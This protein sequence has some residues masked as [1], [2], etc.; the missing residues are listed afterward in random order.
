[1]IKNFFKTALRTLLRNKVYSGIN[2][3]GLSL[4]LAAAMLILLYVKDEVSYDRFLQNVGQIYRIGVDRVKKDGSMSRSSGITGL[5]QG[6]RFAAGVPDIGTYVRLD[7]D[8]I[9]LK[10]GADVNAQ[11]VLKVDSNFLSVFSFPLLSGNP[12]TALANPNDVVISEDLAVKQ[13]GTKEA[14]GKS[15]MFRGDSDRF[16]PYVVRGVAKRCP[17]N[18]SIKFDVLMPMV[19]SKSDMADLSN[20]SNFFINT[21]LV[22]RP[23]SDPHAVEKKMNAVYLQEAAAIIKDERE[24]STEYTDSRFVLQ[25]MRDLH[26]STKYS[27]ANGLKDGSDP[28]YSYILSGIAFFIL[29]IACINF[30]NLTVARSVKRAKEIGIRKVVGSSRKQLIFQFM[31]ESMVLCLIAF[32][33]ALLLVE[34]FL[35]LFNELANKSLALAYLADAKLVL[36]YFAIFL[37]TTFLAG[38]YP[39]LVLSGYQPVETLYQRFNLAGKNYLQK[40]LVVLQFTLASVLIIGTIIIYQQFLFL[41][42]TDLG[43]DDSHVVTASMGWAPMD[44]LKRETLRGELKKN[45]GFTDVAF[46][47]SGWQGTNGFINKNVEINFKFETID[48]RF[49]PMMKIPVVKGRNFNGALPTDSVQSCM[50]NETFVKDAGWKDPIGQIVEIRW[51][52]AKYRVIGVVKDYHSDPLTEKIMPHFFSMAPGKN[53]RLA[54]VKIVPGTEAAGLKFL[55]KTYKSLFPYNTFDYKFKDQENILQYESE[56]RWKNIIFFGA[57]LTIFISCIG[58]FGLSV[59]SAEKRIKE[60]GIRKVLGASVQNVV[61][62]LSMDFVKLVLLALVLA[63]PVSWFAASKWLE[64]YPYRITLSWWMFALAGVLVGVFGVLTVSFQAVKSA[65]ANPTKSLRSE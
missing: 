48:D 12:V 4:G 32:S 20:W 61:R 45:P 9:D 28:V 53:Y 1:M 10:T 33:L 65:T 36:A 5:F 8:R 42:K 14:L 43:Y 29:L 24:K 31:G 15:L 35:P 2:I 50:V 18:S 49:L 26:L 47:N 57:A 34:I 13:F 19:V 46:K 25:P 30:V 40:G 38:F 44:P 63:L 62:I 22:L 7:L 55:R 54:L 52:E 60:I 23:G 59:M 56:S 16:I 39:A 17:Q 6:P 41:T 3:L 58:L 21:F 37:L 11:E 27:P 51:K 64:N